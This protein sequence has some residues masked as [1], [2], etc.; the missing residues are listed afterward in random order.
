MTQSLEH[1]TINIDLELAMEMTTIVYCEET[2]TQARSLQLI[3]E[4]YNVQIV[5]REIEN[6]YTKC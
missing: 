3:S 2:N 1:K 5:L 6:N 4:S